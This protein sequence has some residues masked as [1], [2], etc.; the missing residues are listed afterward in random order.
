[1]RLDPQEAD[2]AARH[3]IEIEI[4]GNFEHLQYSDVRTVLALAMKWSF[5]AGA[6]DAEYWLKSAEEKKRIK[7]N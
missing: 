6:L 1:M 5:E 4:I 7:G 3:Y 2:K